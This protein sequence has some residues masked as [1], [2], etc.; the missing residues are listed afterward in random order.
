MLPPALT[1]G[2]QD[3]LPQIHPA[4]PYIEWTLDSLRLLETLL[5]F[6]RQHDQPLLGSAPDH[7]I[8]QHLVLMA[9]LHPVVKGHGSLER[10]Y[11]PA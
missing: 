8:A 3:S 6:W 2:P 5:A 11:P 7:E 10:G 9:F 1:S 4:R